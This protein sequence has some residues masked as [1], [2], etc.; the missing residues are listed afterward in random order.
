M[1]YYAIYKHRPPVAQDKG[2]R[3][4]LF[5]GINQSSV[6]ITPFIRENDINFNAMSLKPDNQANFFFDDIKVNLF[7][8]K[9]SSI[10]VTS[11]TTLSSLKINEG[12]YG[13][14][15][16]AYAEI[17]GSSVTSTDNIIYVS[18]NFLSV[19]MTK[20]SGAPSLNSTDY[21]VGDLVY[22][23][24]S[25]SIVD[26]DIFTGGLSPTYEFLGKVKKWEYIDATNGVLV[27]DPLLGSL[28][29]SLSDISKNYI[30]NATNPYINAK[31]AIYLH[32]NNRFVSG[33][34]ITSTSTGATLTV[35]AVNSYIAFSSTVS[36]S[37]TSN[38]PIRSIVL[39]SS[40]I[41]RDG[42]S[43]IVGNTVSIVS[44][45]NMGFSANVVSVVANNANGWSEM[46]VDA[47]LPE[48]CTSNSIYSIGTHKINDVGSIYGIFHVPS[49][50]N[51]RWLTGERVFTITDTAT[52]NDD[53]YK[54]RAIAK[55]S[56]VG[57]VDT[58][59][60]TR[61]SV[62]RNQ[63]P[64]TLQAPTNV[65]KST[66]LLN[67]RKYMSQT[68]YTPAEIYSNAVTTSKNYGYYV[69]SID[70][71]FKNKP[72]DSAELLPITVAIS[73]VENGVPAQSI[74]ASK[75]VNALDV[76]ISNTPSS[77]NASTQT[78]F[79]FQDPVYLPPGNEYAIKIITESPDYDVWTATLGQPYVDDFGN[80]RRVSEQ[81]YVGSFFTSQNASN[82]NPI[83]NQDLMFRINRAVF[84]TTPN[85]TF[86][87]ITA[88]PDVAYRRVFDHI[89]LFATE[90]VPTPCE[91]RYYVKTFTVDGTD[92]GYE[93][94]QPNEIYSFA[95]DTNISSLTTQ[96][97]RLV[98]GANTQSINVKVTMSTTDSSVTPIVNRE[99]LAITALTNIIN[100]GGLANNNFVIVDG[101]QHSN[102]ANIVVTISAPNAADGIT[103]TANVQYLVN[104]KVERLN[105]IN[106]GSGYSISPTV[107]IVEANNSSN[108]V[109]AAWS[110]D[111]VTAGNML[112]R[113]V[114]KTITLEQGFEAGD[115]LIG[116]SA[117]RPA[118]TDIHAYVKVLSAL[119]PDSMD[120]KNWVPLQKIRNNVSIDLKTPTLLEFKHS[121]VK[122]EISYPLD[123]RQYPLGGVFKQ[124]KVKICLTSS[125]PTVTPRVEMMKIIAVPGG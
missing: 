43:T 50:S 124:F 2:N 120:E 24:S 92:S 66:V 119:D 105:I 7:C 16:K 88:A 51:L 75:T 15:S 35:A 69:T 12:I 95:K 39:S 30:W 108:A 70:L 64:S 77:S 91:T 122:G 90:T 62:L 111:Q 96:K 106:P 36:G 104:G 112:A 46:I 63:S 29:T 38:T 123:N 13:A 81:P 6:G 5:N 19:H 32:A 100:N 67:D 103:A 48:H 89:K 41:S 86:F 71:F 59:E 18:D 109:V 61:N 117:Y 44:G 97:R 84:E 49:E 87:N 101:G 125:D 121:L 79:T 58:S 98:L 113:Y 80:L 37:N 45:T 110:E 73:P 72:T 55:Y 102:T 78:K 53:S 94:V 82:W 65:I 68:F 52:Y 60:N 116:M 26:F 74:I 93:E 56:A 76:K 21:K 83:L 17:L 10:N 99:R 4:G 22:Q 20:G 33:E 8:Q 9:A 47:T 23:T 3:I 54:M 42:I 114:T 85:T 57:K 34:T 27:I 31:E 107:T 25:N 1:D 28:Q 118:G 14:T 40:N 11:N 115:I